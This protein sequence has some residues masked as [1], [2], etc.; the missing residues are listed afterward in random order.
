MAVIYI[1]LICSCFFLPTLLI[2]KLTN[3]WAIAVSIFGYSSYMAAQFY[4]TERNLIFTAIILGFCAAPL[5]ASK[6]SYITQVSK[7]F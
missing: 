6:C 3:K 2:N 7:D 1:A 4:P 5:W